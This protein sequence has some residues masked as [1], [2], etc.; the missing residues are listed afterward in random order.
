MLACD[1]PLGKAKGYKSP[2]PGWRQQ[3]EGSSCPAEYRPR[4]PED[5]DGGTVY[6]HH[7][8]AWGNSMRSWAHGNWQ[9]EASAWSSRRVW[10]G[11][12]GHFH[13]PVRGGRH[14]GRTKGSQRMGG[15]FSAHYC[16]PGGPSEWPFQIT[17]LF[18]P[19]WAPEIAKSTD[20]ACHVPAFLRTSWLCST[21]ASSLLICLSCLRS[22][23]S[24]RVMGT[25]G[26]NYSLN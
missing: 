13:T 17:L 1:D 2:T 4:S 14:G 6:C 5:W 3:G 22:F 7:H 9:R 20:Q 25:L 24:A 18:G 19:D 15:P 10:L 23:F 8:G 26:H 11:G 21:L 16:R 12:M